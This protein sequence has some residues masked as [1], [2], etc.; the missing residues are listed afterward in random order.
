MYAIRSYYGHSPKWLTRSGESGP[1]RR[2]NA[3][4]RGRDLPRA[5]GYTGEGLATDGTSEPLGPHRITSY[6][7]CYTKLLRKLTTLFIFLLVFHVSANS[8]SQATKFKL[9]LN[10]RTVKD[11]LI[12]IEAQ[13]QF[14]FL[15]NDEFTD[16][17]RVVSVDTD[18]V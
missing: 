7:V 17:N 3:K 10:E 14:H 5:S 4:N 15:Y 6:N 12:E 16:L 18:V 2:S 11:V 8:Y 1:F 13:S 9:K